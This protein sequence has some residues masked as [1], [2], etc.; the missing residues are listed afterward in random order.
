[1]GKK[2]QISVSQEVY[3]RLT[4]LRV[5]PFT[6]MNDVIEALLFQEGRKSR[7]SNAVEVQGN[8]RTM[9]EEFKAAESGVSIST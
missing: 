8:H 3:D 2:I 4:E 5:P 1:M 9:E 6:D 7:A